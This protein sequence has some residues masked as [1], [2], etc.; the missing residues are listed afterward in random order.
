MKLKKIITLCYAFLALTSSVQADYITR[1]F[2]GIYTWWGD[3]SSGTISLEGTADFILNDF[4]PGFGPPP[5]VGVRGVTYDGQLT[6]EDCFYEPGEMTVLNEHYSSDD[7]LLFRF[8][9]HAG[10]DGP[11]S[12][13]FVENKPFN[14]VFYNDFF[15]PPKD[16]MIQIQ[17]NLELYVGAAPVPEP[18]TMF[19][20]GLGLIGATISRRK[21]DI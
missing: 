4:G 2:T 15:S 19:L 14:L 9:G 3:I 20:F 5:W 12:D 1:P 13:I 10:G 8:G 21:V 16:G 6:F 17:S 18:A 7:S 11:R